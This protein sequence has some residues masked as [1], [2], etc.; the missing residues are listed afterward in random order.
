MAYRNIIIQNQAK[1]SLKNRQIRVQTEKADATL[2]IEDVDTVV[3]ENQQTIVSTALLAALA[4]D[5]VAVFIC[6]SQHMPCAILQPFAQHSRSL[7]VAKNQLNLSVPAKK[8][9]WK[10]IVTAKISN[11]ATALAFCG[12]NDASH[13]LSNIAKKV[14]SGD[15]GYTEGYAAAEYFPAL[16]GAG[17]VR[18]DDGDQRNSWLNYGYAIIRGCVARHLAAYGFLPMFGLQHHSTLNQFNLADDFIEPY[19]QVVDLFTAQHAAKDN[20]LTPEVKNQLVNL[21]NYD[22]EISGKKYTL[23]RAIEL[24]VQSF[25]AVCF[26]RGKHL[27]LPKLIQLQMHK[28][29]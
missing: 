15:S 7:E 19:R 16:F 21:I 13:K 9:M 29:E 6:D 14:Q 28:Y 5:N 1:L 10:S 3:I 25:S 4:E 20:V 8:Q 26:G 12:K 2:P 22:I 18:S 17:F 24:S 11:Q 23:S 27:V